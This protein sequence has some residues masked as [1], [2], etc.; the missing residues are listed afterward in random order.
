MLGGGKTLFQG[1]QNRINLKLFQTKTF[2][3]GNVLLY[4]QPL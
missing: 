4:Y 3:S 1:I 2:R